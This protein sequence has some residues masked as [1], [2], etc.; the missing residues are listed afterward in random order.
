MNR[1]ELQYLAMGCLTPAQSFSAKHDCNRDGVINKDTEVFAINGALGYCQSLVSGTFLSSPDDMLRATNYLTTVT[2]DERS[3]DDP[4]TI[5]HNQLRVS[6]LFDPTDG[7]AV[8]PFPYYRASTS[9]VKSLATACPAGF[10]RGG[11]TATGS[12][13]VT[14]T[15]STAAAGVSADPDCGYQTGGSTA[16][17]VMRA[18]TKVVLQIS[19]LPA[20]VGITARI[21]LGL[22]AGD[23]VPASAGTLVSPVIRYGKFDATTSKLATT[24]EPGLYN[25]TWSA[26]SIDHLAAVD[27][28]ALTIRPVSSSPADV[29]TSDFRVLNLRESVAYS[30]D[31]GMFNQANWPDVFRKCAARSVFGIPPGIKSKTA[32]YYTQYVDE[33][34][35]TCVR[36][37]GN[38][39]IFQ[40]VYMAVDASWPLAVEA[41]L[42]RSCSKT[43]G[44]CVAEITGLANKPNGSLDYRDYSHPDTAEYNNLARDPV[45]SA[46]AGEFSKNRYKSRYDNS[47]T[48]VTTF[49]SNRCAR[50]AKWRQTGSA[51]AGGEINITKDTTFQAA[52]PSTVLLGGAVSC[53][54]L[55]AP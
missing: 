36:N 13:F 54:E 25:I 38:K 2:N 55:N 28:S 14:L 9:M 18:G 12:G 35:A 6:S 27:W 4:T 7:G 51:S 10:T 49:L 22:E 11:F 21:S 3:V 39:P 24:L 41:A 34:G 42:L 26:V 8:E 47:A 19:G 48:E 43:V 33:A 5:V 52:A 16:F 30:F 44:G 29:S 17:R 46:I 20:G 32:V 31:G 40:N 53:V 1:S 15:G 45:T 37:H 50:S 23:R